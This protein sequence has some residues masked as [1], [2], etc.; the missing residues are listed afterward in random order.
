M[1]GS[2]RATFFYASR[3]RVDT[4]IYRCCYFTTLFKWAQ[5]LGNMSYKKL[6]RYYSLG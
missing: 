3:I 6:P 2:L 4:V 5:I 1:K